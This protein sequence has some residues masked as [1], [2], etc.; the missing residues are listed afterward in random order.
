MEYKICKKGHYYISSGNDVCPECAK[1]EKN[2]N[3]SGGGAPSFDSVTER[4][5]M[6]NGNY[7]A[8]EVVE[9]Y[10]AT[11]FVS[12]PSDNWGVQ[13]ADTSPNPTL[14]IPVENNFVTSTVDAPLVE[15][16]EP[17]Q[18]KSINGTKGFQPV[19]GWLVCVEGAE[20]GADYRIRAGYNYI[21]RGEHMDICIHGD[22]AITRDR[23]AMIAYDAEGQAFFFGPVNGKDIVRLNGKA[24]MS[25]AEELQA[26]DKIKI[27]STSLM[28]VPLCGERFDWNAK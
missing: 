9:D 2:G 26:Y 3:F 1:E 20:R 17:T 14:P 10:G 5:N 22:P 28:F 23:H 27:G 24:V 12:Y 15:D 18:P 4:V 21:G 8:T 25:K 7:K 19:V 16:Y 6:A 13:E 11:E